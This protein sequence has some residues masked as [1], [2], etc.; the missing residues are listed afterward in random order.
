MLVGTGASLVTLVN[1][2][3]SWNGAPAYNVAPT[4]AG[5]YDGFRVEATA[6]GGSYGTDVVESLTVIGGDCS[7][8]SRY[9]WAFS[10]VQNANIL[11]PGYAEGN[12]SSG[13]YQAYVGRGF[14]KSVVRFTK[15]NGDAAAIYRDPYGPYVYD[16]GIYYA[17]KE[18][19]YLTND[20]IYSRI[21]QTAYMSESSTTGECVW[22]ASSSTTGDT[23]INVS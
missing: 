21:N 11:S 19:S 15:L 5:N 6:D 1:Y 9:G 3:G 7:Y 12:Y 20:I 10:E 4:V 16:S 13:S 17:N 23:D 2:Q 14:V 22:Q 8:N 18:V